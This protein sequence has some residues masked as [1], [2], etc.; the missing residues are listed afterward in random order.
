ME[1]IASLGGGRIPARNVLTMAA[2]PDRKNQE[3]A[4]SPAWMEARDRAHLTHFRR[5]AS[6]R[7]RLRVK[8]MRQWYGDEA[9]AEISAHRCSPA[10]IGEAVGQVVK[11]LGLSRNMLFEEVCV[12]WVQIVG[13]D[14]A[15]RSVPSELHG[16]LLVV[17]VADSSWMYIL[18]TMH[19]AA[20][21][22]K[23]EAFSE[24]EIRNVRF[25]PKGRIRR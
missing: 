13:A 23:L 1:A 10:H 15:G 22:S 17:E 4:S 3:K 5:R 12:K 6:M 11:E 24:N 7:E 25:V 8:V 16:G 2:P 9:M 14:V 21:I 20:L 18:N 19:R